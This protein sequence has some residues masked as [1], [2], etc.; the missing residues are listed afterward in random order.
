VTEC[1]Q[2]LHGNSGSIEYK[3]NQ[4]YDAGELCVFILRH[5]Y[6]NWN[7]TF[8]FTLDADGI[9]ASDA[10]AITITTF[11]NYEIVGKWGTPAKL[12]PP[13]TNRTATLSGYVA[14]VIFATNTSTGTG[15]KLSFEASGDGVDYTPG[16]NEGVDV[17]YNDKSA[18]ELSLPLRPDVVG[19]GCVDVITIT[20]G[21]KVVADPGSQLELLV[22]LNFNPP[23][24]SEGMFIY[25]FEQG[26]LEML[27]W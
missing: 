25:G 7:P 27:E 17:V 18:S 1:G 20:S 15:F 3:L 8:R 2:T 12:G 24:Q 23:C 5:N 4:G 21:A 14:V 26:N 6:T 19:T 11:N 13:N 22:D 10:D 9:S 16:W